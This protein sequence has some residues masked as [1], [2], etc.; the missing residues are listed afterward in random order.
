MAK[1][2]DVTTSTRGRMDSRTSIVCACTTA[3]V[4]IAVPWWAMRSNSPVAA[5][6]VSLTLCLWLA[7]FLAGLGFIVTSRTRA[8]G[9]GMMLGAATAVSGFIA[10]YLIGFGLADWD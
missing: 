2:R 3:A 7:E 8:I 9:L 4:G 10:L 1:T 6:W 5:R